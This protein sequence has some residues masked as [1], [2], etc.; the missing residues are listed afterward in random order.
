MTIIAFSRRSKSASVSAA[1]QHLRQSCVC[2]CAIIPPT[3]CP[4]VTRLSLLPWKNSCSKSS[5]ISANW[6][7]RSSPSLVSTSQSHWPSLGT[8][9]DP[10][11]GLGSC[12]K[13]CGWGCGHTEDAVPVRYSCC[14]H[15]LLSAGSSKY[16]ERCVSMM[17]CCITNHPTTSWL[18]TTHRSP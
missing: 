10:S 17:D 15:W 4:K 11:F 1:S 13:V 7:A 9:H 5:R 3:P 6:T 12:S 18:K 16:Y 8:S 14:L 2:C